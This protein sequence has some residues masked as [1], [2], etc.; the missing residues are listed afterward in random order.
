MK[1]ILITGIGGNIGYH[2]IAQI[3]HNTDWEIVGMDS[4]AHKGTFDRVTQVCH[5][6]PDWL[7]RIILFTHDLNAPITDREIEKIGKIDYILNLAS[8]S[9]VSASIEDPVGT[10]RNNSNLMVNILEYARKIKPEVF[11]QFSTDEVYGPC[12]KDSNGHVEWDTIA[13]SNPYAAS[14]AAQEAKAYSYWRSF[15]LPLII[16]NTMNNFGETQ[17]A[18]KFPAMIQRYINEGKEITVHTSGDGEIGTRYYLHS[19]NAIDAVLFILKNLPPTLHKPGTIDR[20]DRYHIVG[21]EQ[22]S[23]LDLVNIIADLMG[24]KAKVKKVNFHGDQPGHDLHYG[25]Q[26]NK[27]RKAGWKPPLSFRQ[28]MKNTIEWSQRHSEWL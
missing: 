15:G 26:D 3:L 7:E 17:G 23:N 27:L 28:S 10:L 13:P 2:A 6:H 5:D 25:L 20:P 19:R 14:K 11:I 18:S 22:V 1:R 9:D 8:L 16:T 12:G 4:W 24:K 21:S